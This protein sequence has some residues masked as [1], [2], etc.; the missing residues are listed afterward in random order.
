M[1][2]AKRPVD[3]GLPLPAWAQVA[4]D[5]RRE[6]AEELA[7]GDRLPSENELTHVYDVSRIT[8]RQALASLEEEGVVERRQGRG[9]FVSDRSP[10][11]TH[12]LAIAEQWRSRFEREGHTAFSREV[13][14]E[15]SPLPPAGRR[16]LAVGDD[17]VS[18]RLR[19][20]HIVDGQPIGLVDSWV[21]ERKAPGVGAEPLLG[22]SLTETLRERYGLHFSKAEGWMS[23]SEVG[24]EDAELLACPSGTPVFVVEELL[25]DDEGAVLAYSVTRWR[26][27]GVRFRFATDLSVS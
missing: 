17:L 19:R 20:V 1:V 9:T 15:A 7:P 5:L 11:V 27:S 23:V 26:G 14:Q 16:M 8:I 3:R 2:I 12:D 24:T 25:R 21:I 18:P 13:S 4:K 6:V 22:G 10:L